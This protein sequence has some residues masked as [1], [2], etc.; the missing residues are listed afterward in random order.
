MSIFVKL[1]QFKILNKLNH[2]N[3]YIFDNSET[4]SV[5]VG[6]CKSLC[7]HNAKKNYFFQNILINFLTVC[8]FYR[9][10]IT[11]IVVDNLEVS[12]Q[13]C[14]II[15]VYTIQ[16]ITRLRK[17]PYSLANN[18]PFYFNS[19]GFRQRMSLQRN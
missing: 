6:L 13:Y 17:A 5:N 14:L 11:P 3:N 1:T 8:Y 15:I 4:G 18:K 16:K 12:L 19:Y 10:K 9:K 7:T 2:L